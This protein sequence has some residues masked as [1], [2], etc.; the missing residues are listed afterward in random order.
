M[1]MWLAMG[2]FTFV[3]ACGGDGKTPGE[4]QPATPSQSMPAP[5]P[6]PGPPPGGDKPGAC[7]NVSVARGSTCQF[8]GLWPQNCPDCGENWRLFHGSHF[9]TVEGVQYG[10]ESGAYRIPADREQEFKSFMQKQSPVPCAG[11]IIRPPCNPAATHVK[12][13]LDWPPW[14]KHERM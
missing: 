9:V 5:M 2:C 6:S 8:A 1:K 3:S 12:L 13:E 11:V 4:T 14:V 7:R 10:F